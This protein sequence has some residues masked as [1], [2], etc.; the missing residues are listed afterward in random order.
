MYVGVFRSTD[1]GQTW[2]VVNSGLPQSAWAETFAVSPDNSDGT[3]LFV[4]YLGSGIYFKHNYDTIWTTITSYFWPLRCLAVIKNGID[5][6]K[7]FAGGTYGAGLICYTKNDTSW[8][9]DTLLTNNSVFALAVSDDN[10]FVATYDGVIHS[11]DYGKSWVEANSD[12][13]SIYSFTVSGTNLLVGTSAEGVFVSSD[14]GNNWIEITTGLPF[15]DVYGV[16]VFAVNDRYLFAG[17]GEGGVWR[18]PLAEI[19][20]DVNNTT[21]LPKEFALYQNYPN[22]F[23]PRTKISWLLPVSSQVALK[24]YDILGNEIRTLVSEYKQAGKYETEFNAEILPSGVYFYR[25]QAG[26]FVKTKKML[27]IK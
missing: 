19:I 21:E 5:G 15:N 3:N 11:T 7:V 2:T 9:V 6:V 18:R 26:S 10:L 14:N 23:N 20:T 8:I 17:T 12:L 4:G 1:K 22:P 27:L 24:V 25:L 13:G 16:S